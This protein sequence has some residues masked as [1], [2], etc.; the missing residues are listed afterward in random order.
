MK[1]VLQLVVKYDNGYTETKEITTLE[2]NKLSQ[3]TL[4][5][6]INESKSVLKSLQQAIVDKQISEYIADIKQCPACKCHRNIK[7]YCEIVYRTLF[8]KLRLKSP[9]LKRCSCTNYKVAS[10]SP[11]AEL[12]P[13]RSSPELEYLQSKWASLMSYGMTEKL[14]EDIL[15]IDV[16]I[17]SVQKNAHK[18]AKRIES[19]MKVEKKVFIEG[20]QR[21]WEELPTPDMPLTVGLDGGYVHSRDESSR[22]AGWFEVIVGK[23]LHESRESKRFGFVSK[24]DTKPKRRLHDMLSKHGMQANQQITFLSDGAEN[25]KSL[26][27]SISPQ[28]EHILD[29]FHITMKL[30]VLNNMAKSLQDLLKE[31]IPLLLDKIKWCLWNGNIFKALS[32]FETTSDELET[33]EQLDEQ[34]L[35]FKKYFNEF[36]NYIENNQHLIV[37]YNERHKYGE[38][39]STS[40]VESTVNE[41]VSKRMVKRQ[42]MRWTQEGAHLLLQIRAKTLNN[43]LKDHFRKWYPDNQRELFDVAA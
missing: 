37:N 12:L 32:Y 36:T 21:D 33:S 35:K 7:G 10:F 42:Q 17:S 11:L 13:V 19:D 18:V 2:K 8:G 34:T 6:T 40:F 16:D 4:G 9:R 15:P 20:C 25:L 5:L 24:F 30:T 43:E 39:V 28:S 29:W 3:S 23:S 38:I 31:E 41:L 26:Q 1:A 22:K 14:L 27:D